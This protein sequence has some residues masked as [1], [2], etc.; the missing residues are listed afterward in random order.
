MPECFRS[1]S[2]PQ[3][4]ESFRD[5]QAKILYINNDVRESKNTACFFDKNHPFNRSVLFLI[6]TDSNYSIQAAIY[7]IFKVYLFHHFELQIN[8]LDNEAYSHIFTHVNNDNYD[9]LE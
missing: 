5:F 1:K 7:N 8:K 6:D 2:K 4:Y 9:K 3:I